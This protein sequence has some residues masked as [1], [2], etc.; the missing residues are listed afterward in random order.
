MIQHKKN[1]A[2][3]A[4]FFVRSFIYIFNSLLFSQQFQRFNYFSVVF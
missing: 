4:A 2:R 1:A 3:K